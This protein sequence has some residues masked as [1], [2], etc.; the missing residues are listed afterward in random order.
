MP[1]KRQF[2]FVFST[3]D[4]E[5]T[6]AHELGHGVFGL[7]HSDNKDLLMYGEADG[8]ENFT[9]MDWDTM[10]A[11]GFKLYLF[12]SDADGE[13]NNPNPLGSLWNVG[14]SIKRS[15]SEYLKSTYTF[16]FEDSKKTLF[17]DKY[18]KNYFLLQML[19]KIREKGECDL[20]KGTYVFNKETEIEGVKLEKVRLIVKNKIE[21]KLDDANWE[22]SIYNGRLNDFESREGH[23]LD[24]VEYIVDGKVYI[25]FAV[26]PNK[27]EFFK[28][29]LFS[30]DIKALNKKTLGL[31]SKAT[32]VRDELKVTGSACNLCVRSAVYLIKNDSLLFPE[33]KPTWN[34]YADPNDN[35][36][37]KIITG[38]IS[39]NG[40]AKYIKEDFD[41]IGTD[42]D[43]NG[44]YE[45]IKKTKDQTWSEF[46]KA[47]QDKADNAE[48]IIGTMMGSGDVGHIV[49]IT[50]GGLVRI[51]SK[52]Y[53]DRTDIEKGFTSG[54]GDREI[55]TKLPRVLECGSTHRETEAPLSLRISYTAATTKLKWYKYI[56]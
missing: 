30:I 5:H 44:T 1:R 33:I 4:A 13:L 14:E 18:D 46:F 8:G 16:I 22:V 23:L 53:D 28:E 31:S 27:G 12:D 41:D 54:A 47:L 6:L 40:K 43:I 38:K 36:K 19:K 11:A 26:P 48:I 21:G 52:K 15:V 42:T 24:K 20:S 25:T 37:L 39:V 2:G 3:S 51:D 45:E 50:P 10:H 35:Y 17:K 29:Y 49:M 55:I 56:K 7:E 9:H 32:K 34:N